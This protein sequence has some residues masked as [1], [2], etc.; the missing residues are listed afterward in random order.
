MTTEHTKEWW[1]VSDDKEKRE[2]PLPALLSAKAMVVLPATRRQIP[3]PYKRYKRAAD[4]IEPSEK[5]KLDDDAKEL[6]A[7]KTKIDV[8]ELKVERKPNINH[9]DLL[10][11][12]FTFDCQK[13]ADAVFDLADR[14]LRIMF[15]D[16]LPDMDEML[17][18]ARAK[19][20]PESGY[21]QHM[22]IL[23]ALAY[24]APFRSKIRPYCMNELYGFEEF[25]GGMAAKIEANNKGLDAGKIRKKGVKPQIMLAEEFVLQERLHYRSGFFSDPSNDRP[26]KKYKR[27]MTLINTPVAGES[28]LA[29]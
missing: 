17:R 14:C 29:L 3:N 4:Q 10:V 21:L 27:Q 12:V 11:D 7:A 26:M 1:L 2:F 19:E 22:F 24:I 8:L 20:E 28:S 25:C 5:A 15:P 18:V 16:I 23:Y 13:N 6:A 9:P